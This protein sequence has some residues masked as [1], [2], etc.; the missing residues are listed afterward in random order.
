VKQFGERYLAE[1]ADKKKSPRSAREDKRLLE[2]HVVPKLGTRKV[3]DLSAADVAKLVHGL[4]GTPIQANRVRSLLSKMLV[5]AIVWGVRSDPVNP[6]RLVQK[7]AET[8]RERYL[9]GEEV[10]QLGNVLAASE[11]EAEEP[12]QAIAA[13]RLLLFTG[14]RN[15]FSRNRNSLA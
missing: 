1:H 13:I 10:K 6:V 15:W 9:S 14:C 4:S 12:W 8:S 2:R 11:R 7:F 3:A 5:L